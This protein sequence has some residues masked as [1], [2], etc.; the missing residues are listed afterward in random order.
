MAL[1]FSIAVDLGDLVEMGALARA[2]IFP[3]L[4]GAVQRVAEIGVERWQRAVHAAPLWSGEREAYMASIRARRIS[5]L[6]WEVVSDYKFVEDIETGR[7]PYDL[8]KMLDT[9]LKVRV[10]KKGRRYLIIPMRH[11]TP[12]NEAHARPMPEHVYQQA[13]ELAPSRITGHGTRLSGTGAH[14][15]RT[16]QPARV[17][18]RKYLWGDR[19]PAGT[20]PKLRSHHKTDIHAGMVR[21]DNRTPGGK[22]YSSYMTFRVMTQDS[23]GWIIPAK[24]GLWLARNVADSLRRTAEEEFSAAVQRDVGNAA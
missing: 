19:L 17:R 23:A 21:M 24:P 22:R 13:R 20:T 15:V 7:P 2:R 14:D 8:K 18:T 4:A 11:N 6:E 16:K 10:N 12:G 3:S 9:S 5:D 1:S